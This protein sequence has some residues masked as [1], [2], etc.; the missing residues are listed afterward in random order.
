[1]TRLV[2]ALLLLGGAAQAQPRPH[3]D[4][5]KAGSDFLGPGRDAPDPPLPET[6]RV[7]LLAPSRGKAAVEFQRGTTL[8]LEAA[9]AAGGYRGRPFETVFRADD[10]PWGTAARRVVQL[11][12]EDRVWAIVGGLDGHHTHLA[13]LISAKLWVPVVTP[14]AADRTIDYANVPWVFRCPPDDG[15][16]AEALL[17]HAR[18]RGLAPLLVLREDEREARVGDERLVDAARRLGLEAPDALVYPKLEPTRVVAEALRAAPAAILVWG[19]PQTALPLLRALRSG[20]FAGPLLVPASLVSQESATIPGIVATSALDPVGTGPAL[21]DFTQ[22]YAARF[23]ANPEPLAVLSH[24]ALTLTLAAIRQGGLNRAR[25]RDALAATDVRLA[26]GRLRFDGLGGNPAE[27]V[28]LRSTGTGAWR[29]AAPP[30]S[31][32]R[33]PRAAGSGGRSP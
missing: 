18:E 5:S 14:W 6:I 13:E 15:R 26:S 23:G 17:R 7:G 1:V 12:Y 8:A 16:Q 31:R 9:N 11:A 21:R 20:G 25:I 32:S 27:P 22:R 29:P 24:D 28:V 3:R 4:L 19:R 30:T 10:G 33:P 2:P